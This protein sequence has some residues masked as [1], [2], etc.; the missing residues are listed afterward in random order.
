M[1]LGNE[2]YDK[3]SRSYS[4]KGRKKGY[5]VEIVYSVA[6]NY[7]YFLI[8]RKDTDYLFNSLWHYAGFKT[9]EECIAVC[10]EYIDYNLAEH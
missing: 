1:K 7:Y 3:P 10:E 2:K 6:H 8:D 9:E 4:R 5:R